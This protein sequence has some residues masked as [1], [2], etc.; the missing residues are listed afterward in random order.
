[1]P[2]YLSITP[3]GETAQ[4][5]ILE[6]DDLAAVADNALA[7]FRFRE[8]RFEQLVAEVAYDDRFLE[9]WTPV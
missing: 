9:T 6:D 3:E 5:D 8:G 2:Q 4:F 7:V 1:M